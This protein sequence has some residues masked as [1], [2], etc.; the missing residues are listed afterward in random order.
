MKPW[1]YLINPFTDAVANSYKKAVLISTYT[2]AFL[3]ANQTDPFYGPLFTLYNPLHLALVKA[4]N[5]WKN[6]GGSQK[7]STLTVGQLLG[8]LTGKLVNWER[9]ITGPYPKGTP[10][11]LAIFPR[12]HKPFHN[13]SEDLRIQAVGQ[14]ASSL[15]GILALASTY[16][17]V[18]TFYTQLTDA[19][20][21]QEGNISGTKTNSGDVKTAVDAA[22]TLL[23]SILGS[24][25]A[26]FA[27][28]P[29]V[30]EAVFNLQLVREHEQSIFTGTLAPLRNKTIF[31]HTFA[32][33]DTLTLM[34]TGITSL[35]FFTSAGKDDAPGTYTIITVAAGQTV[36]V[37]ASAFG[38]AANAYLHVINTDT[39]SEGHFQVEL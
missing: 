14:L 32:P 38:P 21:A 16:T 31:K 9:D 22:M 20:D 26:Q 1:T 27:A 4:Y 13:G 5:G 23:Y 7:G 15:S 11:Y 34:N 36:T 10:D 39:V 18:S 19:R 35:N 2:N 28:T 3:L 17:D 37:A 25:I 6:Q 29:L 30:I 12:G 8:L 24:C 33:T